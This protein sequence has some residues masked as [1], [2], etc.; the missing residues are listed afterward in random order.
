MD[1]HGGAAVGAGI[2]AG[3]IMMVPLYMGMMMMPSQ[4]RMDVLL[5]LGT[6]TGSRNQPMAY[7]I[8]VMMHGV[9]SIV[10]ALIHVSLYSA[11]DLTDALAAWGVLFGFVHW[12]IV[13]VALGMMR[14]MHP[15]IRSGEME[16]PGPFA[17]SFPTMTAMGFFML[18]ILFGVLVGSFYQAFA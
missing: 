3:A 15:L 4:M 10:F 12:V 5:M 16:N 17:I 8:G 11:F 18:H 9:M 14:T 1:F 7:G 13:G 6:M 2:L